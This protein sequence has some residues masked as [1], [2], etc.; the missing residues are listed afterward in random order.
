M[1]EAMK[2][3]MTYIFNGRGD[4]TDSTLKNSG[5]YEMIRPFIVAQPMLRKDT[6]KRYRG[7]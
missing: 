7:M 1:I 4:M 5:A 2:R 3:F 6:N